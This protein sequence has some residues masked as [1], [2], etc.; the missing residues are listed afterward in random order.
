MKA[1]DIKRLDAISSALHLLL[2][3]Q[4]P[5]LI[6]QSDQEDEINQ[7]TRFVNSVISEQKAL[8]DDSFK[9]ERFN[10]KHI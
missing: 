9:F 1:I 7:V 5:D 4:I 10:A 6:I 2:K 8:L 3:G